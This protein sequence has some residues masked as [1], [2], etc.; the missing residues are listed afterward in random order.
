LQ[1]TRH[2]AGSLHRATS[3]H[4]SPVDCAGAISRG[5]ALWW[6][7]LTG[8]PAMRHPLIA[9]ALLWLPAFALGGELTVAPSVVAVDSG[10]ASTELLLSYRASSG[11]TDADV[12][13]SLSP[14][15]LGWV[16]VQAVPSPT[17]DYEVWCHLV[18][19]RVRALVASRNLAAL[20]ANAPIPLCR[21]RIRPHAH[22]SRGFSN[23]RP[24]SPWE[25]ANGV[26]RSIEADT[27]LVYVP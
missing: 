15:R 24:V 11:V 25:L 10:Q 14:E 8:D 13:Y 2:S 9:L 12:E 1:R 3:S 19:G 23:V 17:P 27:V 21:M 4:S 7:A 16:E 18:D 26:P 22:T 20:P 5:F 6:V